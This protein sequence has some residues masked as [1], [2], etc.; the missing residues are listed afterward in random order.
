[1]KYYKL[2]FV[3]LEQHNALL[4]LFHFGQTRL[5]EMDKVTKKTKRLKL[6]TLAGHGQNYCF[7]D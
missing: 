1:M 7:L 2:C 4:I 5:I 6:F 3:L